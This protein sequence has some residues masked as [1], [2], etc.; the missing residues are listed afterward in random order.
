M[1]YLLVLLM[2]ITA[3]GAR[4]ESDDLG[5]VA[6][7]QALKDAACGV[8]L[9][10]VAAHPD[11][12]DGATLAYYRMKYGVK[13]FAVIATRGE[14]GQNEIGPELYDELAAIRTREM[15]DAALVQGSEPRFLDLP[16]FGFSKSRE[17]TYARWDHDR[18]VAK[19]V[20]LL[21]EVQPTVVITH[22]GL[23]KDHG[24]HQAIG[25]ILL[26]A[27][28]AS[29]D[30][31]GASETPGAG[32]QA[33]YVRKFEGDG[34]RNIPLGALE[35]VRGMTYAQIAARALEAHHSQGMKFFIDRYLSG[36]P[37]ASY[38]LR[39]S[40]ATQANL[41]VLKDELGPLFEGL[42][43]RLR[44]AALRALAQQAEAGLSNA[45]VL[46]AL[47]K[48]GSKDR[49][50]A[51]EDLA[52]AAGIAAEL[53]VRAK[54]DDDTV[55]RG[56]TL[57]IAARVED[58]GEADV[59]QLEVALVGLRSGF[60][61]VA[62]HQ[63]ITLQGGTAEVKFSVAVPDLAALTVPHAEHVFDNDVL[64]R[65]Q[66]AVRIA[67]TLR[68][69]VSFSR[70]VPL[71]VE[72]APAITVRASGAPYLLNALQGNTRTLT[73]PITVQRH[74]PGPGETTV[75][76]QG[77]EGWQVTPG[78][79][80]VAFSEAEEER[81]VNVSV[82][83]PKSFEGME[84]LRVSLE[85]S[86]HTATAEVVRTAVALPRDVMVGLVRSYDD[87]L[88]RTLRRLGIPHA[89]IAEGDFNREALA[90]FTTVLVD[91][92]AYQYRPDLV[93]NGPALVDY[94]ERGGHVVVMYQKT[95]DWRPAYAPLPFNIVN[96]RVTLEDAP[97]K[98]LVPEHP[99]FTRPNRLGEADWQGW[100][101]ERGLYFAGDW[102]KAYT[103]LLA[104]ND[105]GE[106]PPP[107][108]L[109]TSRVG[110]GTYT[111][112]ALALYRQLHQLKPGALRLFANLL[113][114]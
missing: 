19:M 65:A 110:Q 76:V 105:P 77:P 85:G 61:G 7:V 55:V 107:G 2:L 80:P 78:A 48:L 112:C 95:F 26:E 106:N 91:M 102:D 20:A 23:M 113:D 44:P 84:P 52:R 11:D 18:A 108:A 12:E 34:E 109:I 62:Q 69:G 25:Q 90:R 32:V 58:F 5:R 97:M 98:V 73:V 87:T 45:A 17:E 57:A 89:L 37:V 60:E 67:G 72:V 71:Y 21:R 38:H 8:R 1:R 63:T 111:Y 24:H 88:E 66:L 13:T 101:Q 43:V 4:A 79:I 35:P 46:D 70:E 96:N 53:R 82:V 92:R 104:C 75:R 16:E 59:E 28:E 49:V 47:A 29:H 6:L 74:A 54:A 27:V 10:C 31:A 103:P 3:L 41:P 50:A 100:V 42:Q 64:Y 36:S 14:G 9:M 81:S 99:Y 114:H 68:N 56:Q 39:S 86:P 40:H 51:P 93:A 30:A 15:L 83:V 33:L 22:H 94:L